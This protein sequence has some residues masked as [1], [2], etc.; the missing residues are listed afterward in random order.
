LTG[1]KPWSRKKLP[2]RASRD[3]GIFDNKVVD[4]IDALQIALLRAG[5]TSLLPELYE[6]FGTENLLKFLDVFAGTTIVVPSAMVLEDSI[7]D[8]FIY[9]IV[10]NAQKNPKIDVE[11]TVKDLADRYRIGIEKVRAVYADMK[12][13]VPTKGRSNVHRKSKET[14]SRNHE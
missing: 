10:D 13:F 14:S 5:S 8:T 11:A 9:L 12:Q 7:R 1:R 4:H 6:I 3:F 2:E